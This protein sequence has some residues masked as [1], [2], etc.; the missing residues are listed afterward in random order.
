M[1]P[2]KKKV[3]QSGSLPINIGKALVICSKVPPMGRRCWDKHTCCLIE[4]HSTPHR[5]KCGIVW[6][7]NDA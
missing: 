1:P 6:R 5:T 3:K 4:G 2:A 7:N